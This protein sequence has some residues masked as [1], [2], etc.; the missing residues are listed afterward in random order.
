METTSFNPIPKTLRQQIA[1]HLVRSPLSAGEL[2][3][4]LRIR[5]KEIY[6]HLEHLKRSLANQKKRLI[7]LP[8]CCLRCGFVFKNRSRFTRPGRCPRCKGTYLEN[9]LFEI[10]S[11]G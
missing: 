4:I 2:S 8:F 3:N 6:T 9:P 11:S 10:R 7:V 5:E 1:A